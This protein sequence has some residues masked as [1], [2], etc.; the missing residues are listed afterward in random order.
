MRS[1]TSAIIALIDQSAIPRVK[2]G[3]LAAHSQSKALVKMRTS[4]CKDQ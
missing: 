1:V 3:I 2:V 4:N